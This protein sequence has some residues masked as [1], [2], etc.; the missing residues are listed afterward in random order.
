MRNG[1]TH[2]R[3]HS[4]DAIDTENR[5]TRVARLEQHVDDSPVQHHGHHQRPW[6]TWLKLEAHQERAF[7]GAAHQRFGFVSRK[8]TVKPAKL[9]QIFARPAIEKL[10]SERTPRRDS[11]Q[12]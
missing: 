8:L 3:V 12:H 2:R 7:A 11:G 10:G 5:V 4:R 6:R 9:A 1:C